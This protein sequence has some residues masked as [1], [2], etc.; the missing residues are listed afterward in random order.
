MIGPETARLIS[1]ASA[2]P[3]SWRGFP[4]KLNADTQMLESA[5]TETTVYRRGA[6]WWRVY[7]TRSGTSSSRMPSFRA[8]SSP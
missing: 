5:V 1:S 7:F 4:A 6:A 8:W 3:I 2:I